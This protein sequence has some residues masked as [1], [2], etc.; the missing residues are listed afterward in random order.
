MT[1]AE[2]DALE[3]LC[4]AATPARWRAGAVEK[5]HVFA[6]HD[7]GLAGL[8]GERV[9]LRMN[10]HFPHEADA[11][12]I[13]AAREAVPALI[14][15]VRHLRTVVESARARFEVWTPETYAA[16]QSALAKLDEVTND[17]R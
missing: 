9:L 3:R 1:P 6:R 16:L 17:Q 4:E 10:E 5:H 2:L 12:F 8:G 13:A 7:E 15:E 14:A 11:A